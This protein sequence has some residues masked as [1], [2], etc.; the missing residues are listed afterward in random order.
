MAERESPPAAGAKREVCVRQ[1]IPLSWAALVVLVLV[2]CSAQ[3]ALAVTHSVGGVSANNLTDWGVTPTVS[4]GQFNNTSLNSTITLLGSSVNNNA[5]REA[6]GGGEDY[7]IESLYIDADNN[8]IYFASIISTNPNGVAFGSY[9]MRQGDLGIWSGPHGTPYPSGDPLYGVGVRQTG[10]HQG[11]VV[12]GAT[13]TMDDGFVG[14]A[15]MLG[16]TGTELGTVGDSAVSVAQLPLDDNGRHNW[17]V[18]G[19]FARSL[20]NPVGEYTFK[21]GPSCNNDYEVVTATIPQRTRPPVPEPATVALLA[22]GALPV[23]PMLR[24]RRSA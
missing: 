16:S 2:V 18:K 12:Q 23:L 19:S 21:F 10:P 7:D 14:P 9:T 13:W 4:G 3:G 1:R 20:F 11:R 8:N 15:Y 17:V 5:Y 22:I 6:N 24:R